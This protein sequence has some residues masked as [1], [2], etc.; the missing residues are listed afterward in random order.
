MPR[1]SAQIDDGDQTERERAR[2]CARQRPSLGADWLKMTSHR[3]VLFLA[4]G[5]GMTSSFSSLAQV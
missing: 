5:N 4:S 1:S 3:I 2:A